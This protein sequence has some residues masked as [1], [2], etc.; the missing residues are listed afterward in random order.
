MDNGFALGLISELC[1]SSLGVFRGRAAVHLG[2]NRKQLGAMQ[3]SGIVERVLPDTYRMT[4]VAPSNEQSLR[5]ALLWA[6]PGAV[7]AGL[8][9]GE[10]YGLGRVRAMTPEIAVTSPRRVRSE[11]VVVH[12][13]QH[14]GSIARADVARSP[15]DGGGADTGCVGCCTRR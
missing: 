15:S 2:V 4:A 3:G 8:S 12:E 9:A 5:A 14:R 13:V 7:A 10:L 11:S 1:R 6:G